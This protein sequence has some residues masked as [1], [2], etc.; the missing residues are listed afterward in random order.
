MPISEA[1]SGKAT[2]ASGRRTGGRSAR[3]ARR[4]GLG[5]ARAPAFITRKIPLYDLLDEEALR[6]LEAQADWILAEIGVEFRGDDE[7]LAL[8][9]DAGASVEGCRVRF[10][11]AA[12]R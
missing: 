1:V 9:R 6:V 2:K 11:T 10:E 5:G 12:A 4:T 8:F 3:V 7:A